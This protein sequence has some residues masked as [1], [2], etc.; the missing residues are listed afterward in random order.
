MRLKDELYV[1]QFSSYVHN[2]SHLRK[3]D[4]SGYFKIPPLRTL[5]FNKN[6]FFFLII[7]TFSYSGLV[8][9]IIFNFL[10]LKIHPNLVK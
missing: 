8:L 1:A 5:S 4:V 7:G 2:I 10:F 6:R 9:K 3:I